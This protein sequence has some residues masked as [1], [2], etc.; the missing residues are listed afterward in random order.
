MVKIYNK[1]IRDRIPTIIKDKGSKCEYKVLDDQLFLKEL[2][3]KLREELREY[4]TSKDV[5]EL[6]DILEIIYR[7]SELKGVS[8]TDLEQIREKKKQARGGL[9]RNYYLLSTD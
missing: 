2:E 1:A 9:A 7:I 8:K 3:L 4:E 6:T 5:E